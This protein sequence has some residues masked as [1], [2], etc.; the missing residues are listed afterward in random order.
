MRFTK[1][2]GLNKSQ[3][4]LDFVDIDP[5]EDTPLFFDPYVFANEDDPFCDQC[6]ESLN[7]FFR[8]P[9]SFTFCQNPSW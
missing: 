9:L 8:R 3:A 1:A 4:G 7:S 5:D 6:D 2:F